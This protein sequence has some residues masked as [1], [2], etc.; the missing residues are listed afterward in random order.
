MNRFTDMLDLTS[1][2][3]GSS[4]QVLDF[5]EGLEEVRAEVGWQEVVVESSMGMGEEGTSA[6]GDEN[7]ELRQETSD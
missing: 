7:P 5:V 4:A 6:P 2:L 1:E 3:D